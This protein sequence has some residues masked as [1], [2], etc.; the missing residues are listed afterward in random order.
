MLKE[1]CNKTIYDD[2]KSKTILTDEE[3]KILD[4]LILK[5]SLVK[6]AQEVCMSDRNVS[7]IV[8]DIKEKYNNYKML[9]LAK[10]DIFISE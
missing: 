2:F 1:L 4:M 9:E 3:I 7:R 8:K 10:L 5:Y 6:I